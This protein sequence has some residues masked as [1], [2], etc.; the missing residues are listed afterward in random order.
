LFALLVL[1]MILSAAAPAMTKGLTQQDIEALREQGREEDWTFTVGENWATQYEL[2]DLCGLVVPDRWWEGARFDPCTP[3][4]ALPAR[5]DWR[6]SSGVTIVK[7]QSSCGSCWAFATVGPLECN[8]KIKDGIEVDLSEA[9]LVSCNSEGWGCGGGWW[10]HDYHQWK[11]DP[12]GGTG[13]VMEADFTYV[14]WERPCDCPYPHE[15]FI[16]DW[17][18]IGSQYGIPPVDNIKQ[19]IMD[20][21]PVSVAVYANSAMQ[22]Y[23]GGIFNGCENGTTNHAVVLVGWDDDQGA[24]GVWFMRNSWFT[25][26]GEDGGYMRIPYD[27]SQIGYS[28]CYVVY[29]GAPL[30]EVHLPDGV[31]SIIE[32][33]TAT[34]ITVQI[35]ENGDS[36]VPGTGTLHYRYDGGAYLTS[37]LVHLSGDLYQAT[38]P[39][40][41]CSDVPEY[42]FS[43]E[44]AGAGVITDPADA[45][46]TVYSSQVGE[47]AVY[48]SDD[49]ETDQGWTV[50]NDPSLTDG[51]WD[52][53][54]PAGG[55]DRGDP[56]SD[57]DGSGQC[58][59]TDNVDDNSDV[60]GGTT[61]LISP[62]ID[63]S[64]IADAQVHYAL[65]YT[66]DF[67]ADPNNDIFI[68]SVSNDN[69][70]SWTAADTVGP[71]SVSGWYEYEFMV[72]DFV[73][74]TNQV[75]VRFEASDLNDGSVV[76]AGIDDFSVAA[77]SCTGMPPDAIDDLA[78]QLLEGDI[79]L[80]WTEPGS[81]SGVDRY[82]VYRSADAAITG[83]SLAGTSAL[84]YTD[85]GA[86]GSTATNYYYTVK[87]VGGGLKSEFS[88]MAGEFD[89]ELINAPPAK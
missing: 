53:G 12:C 5:F 71:A 14:P 51:S 83:D 26:W 33:G 16:D 38:L 9:W 17:A 89:I 67:G 58:Y 56:A 77:F 7:D 6:D 78:V 27:C 36:Y 62:T 1:S 3:S 75:R 88:N 63:L 2:E 11:T 18:Y 24:D 47:L 22:A 57:Y 35:D 61:W 15:Y 82:I 8:I 43:A 41:T 84:E 10:A 69:G 87:A 50:Q 37:P 29:S 44:G 70:S 55:G 46:A 59:L 65:W 32:P 42:Y 60:D 20:Y 85:P 80:Q 39:A 34:T 52:R 68:T 45:P 76:E 74:P 49:F 23:T 86:A 4:K 73:T 19:A 81:E 64:G 72:A 25:T 40:A 66:N 54:V 30:L 13:A 28:A 79:V 31:P 21:G 48:F